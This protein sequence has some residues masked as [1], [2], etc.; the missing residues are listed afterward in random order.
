LKL[1]RAEEGEWRVVERERERERERREREMYRRE[2][3]ERAWQN[4]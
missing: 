3:V 4:E 1:G 2:S